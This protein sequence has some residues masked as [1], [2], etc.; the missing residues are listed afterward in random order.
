MQRIFFLKFIDRWLGT[1][2][3]NMLPKP[4]NQ[5]RRVD[6][7]LSVL[8]I[9]PGGIGDAVHLVPVV[10]ALQKT[11]P[12][13]AIDILAEC[14]NGSVFAMC[15]GIRRIIRYDRPGQLL[16][17]LR[18][19][20][21]VVIDSEQW[22]RLSAVVARLVRAPMKIGFAT[23]E[24]RRLFT[25]ALPYRQDDY[26]TTSFLR[27]LAPLGIPAGEVVA[28]SWLH[29]P[30]DVRKSVV[31]LLPQDD[32]RPMVVIFPG[33]SIEEKR[34]GADR[35][36][37]VAK[38]CLD[39]SLQVVLVGG[40]GDRPDSERIA[41]GLDIVNLAGRT[42][43]V[44]TAAIIDAAAVVVSG[45]SGVLHIAAGLGRPTVALFGPSSMEKW[46]PRGPRHA[47][48][49]KCL[50]CSPCSRFGY[51][52]S[53]PNSGRCMNDIAVTDVTHAIATLL[54]LPGGDG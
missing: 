41:S 12:G 53:C 7:P 19:R 21:D 14:R 25:H 9:R 35:F 39:R 2:L 31:S 1:T 6:K 42:S 36:R 3:A 32:H 43:L 4:S 45:D 10:Y 15:P 11:F 27:L 37:S 33:A 29:I 30:E 23:N 24:R 46:A 17:A 48:L 44:Q 5:S 51:T 16:Q 54:K 8:F 20:Y 26:E 49:S 28:D 22:H 52:P 18:S 38:W 47:T 40:E 13:I 34:W 50:S